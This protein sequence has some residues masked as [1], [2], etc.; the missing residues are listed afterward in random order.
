MAEKKS[1]PKAGKK[2]KKLHLRGIHT[3]QARDG[4]LVHHHTYADSKDADYSHPER[5]NMATSATPEEAGQHVAEQFAQNSQQ[6]EPEDPA[7]G[8]GPEEAAGGAPPAAAAA[9][10]M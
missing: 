4:S 6:Q 8:A 1:E 5:R 2:G 10:G 9:A 3:E 7:A